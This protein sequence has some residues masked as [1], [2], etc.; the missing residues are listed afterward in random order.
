MFG[1]DAQ[2]KEWLEPLLDGEIRSAFAMTE[3]DVAS[4]DATNIATRIERDGDEYVI[5]GRKWWITG[6]MNPNARDLHRDGQDRPDRRPAPPAVDDPGP[7]GHPRRRDQARHAGVRVRR[8]R[9]RRPRRAALHRR[10]GPGGE[11]DRRRGRRLRHRAGPARPGPDP[12]LHALD[13]RGRAGHRADVRPRRRAGRLRQADRRAGR[14]PRLDRRVPGADRAAAAAGPQ[15]RLA[16]G[17]RRQQGRAHRDPG[18]QDRHPGHRAVDPR[19]GD[20]GARR[21][22]AVP[23]LPAGRARTPASARCASPT[24]RTRCTRTPWPRRAAPPGGREG[25]AHDAP[26]RRRPAARASPS[27][28]PP[29]TP[30]PPTGWSSSAPAST[31]GWPGCHFP[32]GHGGLGLPRKRSSPTWTGCF[33]AAGAPD[34]NPQRNGIGLGMAAPTILAFGTEEQKQRFL[35]PLWTGEEVWCQLFSEPG[36]GSDLAAVAHP[37]GA[38]RRRLGGQRAE[39]VDVERPQRPIRDPGRPHRPGRAQARRAHLLPAAT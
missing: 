28:S 8:P 27:S 19:Q 12:P 5:N 33:A 10:P 3:P 13:R 38:R 15:D 11:P 6:A 29:T 16:D 17:H 34:N 2:Q 22:R 1:T 25:G 7:A 31:P 24:A 18:D 36:A 20:P 9:P 39:G 30:R 21:R 32:E 23:G 4:S 37:R 35:R 14:G 26:T